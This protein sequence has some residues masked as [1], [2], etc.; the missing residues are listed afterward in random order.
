[1]AVTTFWK[2]GHHALRVWPVMAF[3]A[4]GDGFMLLLVAEA[5]AFGAMFG[6]AGVEQVKSPSVAGCTVF[7]LH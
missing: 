2:L 4:G 1:M 6:L 7:V 3:L 5:T